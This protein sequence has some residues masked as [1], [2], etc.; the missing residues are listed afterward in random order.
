VSPRHV[1]TEEQLRALYAGYREDQYTFDRMLVESEYLKWAMV[2]GSPE[3]RDHRNALTWDFL[4]PVLAPLRITRVC[5]F[6]GSTG[7]H[8]PPEI[9]DRA[10][11][12]L[13]TDVSGAA[14]CN[15][16]FKAAGALEPD[17]VDLALC[18]H[19]LEHVG[20][21]REF[22]ASIVSR[23]APGGLLYL[24]LPKE[25]DPPIVD[26][27]RLGTARLPLHEHINK[28]MLSSMQAMV[29]SVGLSLIVAEEFLVDFGEARVTNLRC[30]AQ[31]KSA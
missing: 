21:P 22:L 2:L 28:F 18:M 12:I 25:I 31:K 26:R 9:V 24:E 3:L 23:I 1:F 11:E 19:V 5:D 10:D 27:L 14:L 8:V 7:E 16:R 30:L 17:S 6:G 15:P 20:H 4:R 13:V 29:T